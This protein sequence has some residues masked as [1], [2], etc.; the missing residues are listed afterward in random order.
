MKVVIMAGGEGTRL[1]PISQSRPKPMVRLYDRPVLE[2]ILALLKENGFDEA[3]LTLRYLPRMVT[4]YFGDGAKFG[5]KLH[6]K[7][8]ERPLGTAGGV[9]NCRGYIGDD[10]VLVISG[11]CVCD[12][13]LR[14]IVNFHRGKNA[15]ATLALY[16]H[17]NPLEYGL[18]VTDENGRVRHFL[19][20]PAWDRVL[21]DQ[22]NTGIYILSPEALEKIPP[23][24]QYDFGKDLFP[25]LLK[26]NA[27]LYGVKME[28][29]WC[30]IGSTARPPAA[31]TCSKMRLFS[32]GSF[33]TAPAA[34]GALSI[35][36][37]T[38][39][40]ARPYTSGGT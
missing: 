9:L 7:I 10:D 18:V 15:A 12:F 29:Y 17:P 38:S 30:D 21:T 2:H 39:P 5:M 3:C 24:R 25:R 19:E 27:A 31:W 35:Y 40:S 11:D 1:R 37:I 20:K 22:I 32:K 16:S 34:S 36:R 8:E 26:E 4:D 33:R 6:Y 13:D 28:G 14:K 23:D